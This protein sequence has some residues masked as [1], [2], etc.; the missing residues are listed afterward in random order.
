VLYHRS[1]RS[2]FMAEQTL[3]KDGSVTTASEA[4][5]THCVMLVT[6]ALIAQRRTS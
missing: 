6:L 3:A 1:L 2:D 5:R 4:L